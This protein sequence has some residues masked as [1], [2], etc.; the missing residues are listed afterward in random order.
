MNRKE[1]TH[2][3]SSLVNQKLPSCN[4]LYIPKYRITDSEPE[5]FELTFS[6]S[7]DHKIG[8]VY[9]K[10]L[11]DGRNLN[12]IVDCYNPDEKDFNL[13]NNLQKVIFEFLDKQENR[14]E[15]KNE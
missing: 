12:L 6:Q 14:Y 5:N 13:M 8:G 10:K 4:Q 11:Y 9:I 3:I 2:I 15:G 1:Y 7:F